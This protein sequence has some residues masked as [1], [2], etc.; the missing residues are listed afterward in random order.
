MLNENLLNSFSLMKTQYWVEQSDLFDDI[1]QQLCDQW[2]FPKSHNAETFPISAN[3][4][5]PLVLQ[6]QIQNPKI[7]KMDIPLYIHAVRLKCRQHLIAWK[8][9]HS[10]LKSLPYSMVHRIHN[11]IFICWLT[12]FAVVAPLSMNIFI[13]YQHLTGKC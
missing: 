7:H 4:S 10:A 1:V 12:L 6:Q 8:V 5:I 11:N 2:S 3:I 9:V 13:I